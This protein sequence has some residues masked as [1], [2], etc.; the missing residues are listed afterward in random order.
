MFCKLLNV[1]VNVREAGG[2]ED[3][4]F[5]QTFLCL[6][7]WCYQ[8]YS[9]KQSECAEIPKVLKSTEVFFLKII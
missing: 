3:C 4:I 9:E 6:V 1:C 8:I 5:K 7:T 2:V